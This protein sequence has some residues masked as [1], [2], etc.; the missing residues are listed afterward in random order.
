MPTTIVRMSSPD[1]GQRKE[2]HMETIRLCIIGLMV[3]TVA[4]R[5]GLER[6][7]HRLGTRAIIA[8]EGGISMLLVA[9]AG[10]LVYMIILQSS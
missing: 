1:M 2:R 10:L 3:A 7:R 6:R 8:V 9:M 4:L 5:Y